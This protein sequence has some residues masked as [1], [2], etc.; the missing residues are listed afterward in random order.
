M[1]FIVGRGRSGTSVLARLLAHHPHISVPPECP[2][3]LHLRRTHGR[4][5]VDAGRFVAD[6][7]RER[8]FA[9]WRLDPAALLA[10]LH[11]HG[12]R[13][14]RLTFSR[15]CR[16]VYG[17][18]AQRHGG[19]ERVRVFGDKNPI[20]SLYVSALLATFPQARFVHLVR[21]PRDNV[22]SFLRV[23]FDA[24]S[25]AVLAHR[26]VHYHRAVERWARR[27]PA[28]FLRLR[29]EDLVGRPE[30][31]LAAIAAFLRVREHPAMLRF[32][33]RAQSSPIRWHRRQRHPLHGGRVGRWRGGALSHS[34]VATVVAICGALA[35]EFG[36]DVAGV[37]GKRRG[38][39]H[40]SEGRVRAC[41]YTAAERGAFALPLPLRVP[42]IDA[43][44]HLTGGWE[45]PVATNSQVL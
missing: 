15:A 30:E 11:V 41:L 14:Q 27:Y 23:P 8:R 3:V 28:R 18:Y 35:R 16:L 42:V 36:Y 21:D 24:G 4:G 45:R 19:G 1:F 5:P 2:F 17:A 38:L 31:I 37:A 22:A 12:R 40:R 44:R 25:A 39:V 43:Y 20:H 26:W 6:L 29:Y 10:T 7:Q 9:D 33:A 13:G 34:E 32:F